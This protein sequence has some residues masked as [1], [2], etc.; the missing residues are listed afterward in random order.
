MHQEEG[1][2]EQKLGTV[3]GVGNDLFPL[4]TCRGESV[5]QCGGVVVGRF[6][7]RESHEGY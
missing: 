6:C 7:E 1:R 3:E 4:F 2:K 5:L